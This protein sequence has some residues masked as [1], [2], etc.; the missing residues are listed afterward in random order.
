MMTVP[1]IS[2]GLSQQSCPIKQIILMGNWFHLSSHGSLVAHDLAAFLI[3]PALIALV[4][5]LLF[6]VAR[7]I[8]TRCP[9]LILIPLTACQIMPRLMVQRMHMKGLFQFLCY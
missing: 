8:A 1:D 6:A 2:V 5:K 9:L 7:F 3:N 4:K